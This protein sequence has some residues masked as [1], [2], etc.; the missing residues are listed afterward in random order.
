[1]L[2]ISECM[3]IFVVKSQLFVFPCN[4]DRGVGWGKLSHR[5]CYEHAIFSKQLYIYPFC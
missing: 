3:A 5:T 2:I 1:M 4:L